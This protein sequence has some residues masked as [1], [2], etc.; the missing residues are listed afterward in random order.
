[1][2]ARLASVLNE[3]P[4][5]AD[6]GSDRRS[7]AVAAGLASVLVASPW[8]ERQVRGEYCKFHTIL[9]SFRLIGTLDERSLLR[10]GPTKILILYC[11]TYFKE[12]ET[13]ARVR[14]IFLFIS[15]PLH[16]RSKGS[17]RIIREKLDGE[18]SVDYDFSFG[19]GRA[20]H[21]ASVPRRARRRRHRA[22]RP[23]V[24]GR[25]SWRRLGDPDDV[26]AALPHRPV[27]A[28]RWL[29]RRLSV[30]SVSACAGPNREA[31]RYFGSPLL[32]SC[33]RLIQFH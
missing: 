14:E 24:G 33:L 8:L 13:S 18:L 12:N 23:A 9:Y 17:W 2:L 32:M 20:D 10:N 21:D 6:E 25:S 22:A 19:K 5:S 31:N 30:P 15:F 29:H 16:S 11:M 7:A 28:R 27:A 26:A 3:E 1:M 4:R